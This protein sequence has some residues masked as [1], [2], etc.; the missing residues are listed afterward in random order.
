MSATERTLDLE[1]VAWPAPRV[2]EAIE[3]LARKAGLSARAAEIPSAPPNIEAP[4]A[5]AR[6]ID[7]AALAAGV[8]AEPAESSCA[9]A[10]ALVSKCG[11][12]LLQV[13]V[14]SE[15]RFLAVLAAGRK[16]VCLLSPTLMTLHVEPAA[17][18]AALC[19]PLES[20]MA[21]E[22]EQVLAA[23]GVPPR[24]RR[25]ARAAIL[26]QQLGGK[27]LGN[28]W[29]LRLPAGAD[30]WPQF[31]E[32]RILSRLLGLLSAHTMQYLLWLLSWWMIGQAALQGRF[33]WGWLAAWALVLFSMLPF[34]LMVTWWQG[35]LSLRLGA[36]LKRRLLSG[37]LQL[38]PEEVRHQGAGQ[39]LGCVIESEAVESLALSGGFLALMSGLELVLAAA[40]LAFGPCGGLHLCLLTAWIGVA[41]AMAWRY[42]KHRDWWTQSRLNLTNDLVEK[43]VGHRTRLAQEPRARWHE[44]EDH[45]LSGLLALAVAMDQSACR[46]AA[47]VPRGWLLL[48][49]LA[50]TPAFALAQTSAAK[51]AVGLGGVLLAFRALQRFTG[52]LSA[53][54]GAAIAWKQIAPLFEAAGRELQ[55]GPTSLL[56]APATGSRESNQGDV[57]LEAHEL[58]FHYPARGLPVLRQ[59]SLTIRPGER[60]VLEGV[61]GGGKST[62]ASLLAGLRVPDSGLLLLRGLD[63]Q[64]VGLSGWRRHVAASPQFHENHV[65]TGTFAFNLLMGSRWPPQ[66]EAF[67]AAETL[68]QELGLGDL[69]QRMPAGLLQLVGESGWQLSHGEKSRL[70]IARALL[71]GAELIV[72]D[73]SFASLDP[74]NLRRALQCVLARAK[75]LLVIA[76]P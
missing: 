43:M 10:E 50:L 27:R 53:L 57:L 61:S 38:E 2:G 71:Q 11:P 18:R 14:G 9:D 76:H 52:G 44:G 60:I 55:K 73:E 30:L 54:A 6:W 49:L 48:G 37:A 70:Y 5:L 72:L 40:V 36:L 66:P 33:D 1:K 20:A 75:T 17:V 3:W 19:D 59:C 63:R 56:S 28:C 74:E 51:L 65:L 58:N 7:A 21:G 67:Q 12:A 69:L 34:R 15:S 35:L 62:L 13:R 64:T 39:L 8:E 46:L 32:A 25:R 23:A 4:E 41:L 68:C 24:R 22:A 16:R 29:L 42:S 26:R 47:L 31:R 45:G